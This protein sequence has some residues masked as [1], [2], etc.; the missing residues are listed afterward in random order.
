MAVIRWLAIV[1]VVSVVVLGAIIV[2]LGITGTTEPNAEPLTFLEGTWKS[3]MATLDPGTMGGDEGWDYRI[4]R[5]T[6]TLIGIF[7][8]SILIGSIASGI[9]QKIEELKRGRSR[10]IDGNHTLILG[11]SEKIFTIITFRHIAIENQFRNAITIQIDQ[12]IQS[13]ILLMGRIR[14][15]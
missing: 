9:D 2:L 5:F 3:L 15:Q 7:L 11:W 13:M 4:V 10:V 1:S 8:I 14:K 6:A 12:T